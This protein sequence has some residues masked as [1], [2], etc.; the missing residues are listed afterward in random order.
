MGSA[1]RVRV[2]AAFLLGTLL[3]ASGAQASVNLDPQAVAAA[4]LTAALIRWSRGVQTVYKETFSGMKSPK[5]SSSSG[6]DSQTRSGEGGLLSGP[7][8]SPFELLPKLPGGFLGDFSKDSDKKDSSDESPDELLSKKSDE[9]ATVYAYEKASVM[10]RLIA[11]PFDKGGVDVPLW[12]FTEGTWKLPTV[13]EKVCFLFF[14]GTTMLVGTPS[15]LPDSIRELLVKEGRVHPL[16]VF[17]T[18]VPASVAES[19]FWPV[20]L[21]RLK[22]S[23]GSVRFYEDSNRKDVLEML[24]Y[25]LQVT[26]P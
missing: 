14:T 7:M 4:R 17:R 21:E 6:L 9:E 1:V 23:A 15:T 24:V 5:P 10:G 3:V 25:P 22:Q 20:M 19:P 2:F 11:P 16:F 26:L 8:Q 12:G 18:A 13:P